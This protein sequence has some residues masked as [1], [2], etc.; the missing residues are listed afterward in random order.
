[1]VNLNE[2]WPE[3]LQRMSATIA[4][5][6]S[7]T[8]ETP[9]QQGPPLPPRSNQQLYQP[10]QWTDAFE[11]SASLSA[12]LQDIPPSTKPTLDRS[13][14]PVPS[15]TSSAPQRTSNEV[16]A[17]RSVLPAVDDRPPTTDRVAEFV[18]D[19]PDG[20]RNMPQHPGDL[21]VGSVAITVTK[22]TKAVRIRL[23]FRGQQRVY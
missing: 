10:Q 4:G 5:D 19:I 11:S 23:T 12:G 9:G 2:S 13:P 6:E 14:L 22:P 15:A 18:L 21:I 20:V 3:F 7:A 16:T 17:S 1:M 8:Q